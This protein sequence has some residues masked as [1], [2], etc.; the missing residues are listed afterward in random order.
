LVDRGLRADSQRTLF[1]ILTFDERGR[2][3]KSEPLRRALAEPAA[4]R[5]G[6][7]ARGRPA[8][9]G[10]ALRVGE[11]KALRLS[12]SAPLVNDVAERIAE[13]RSFAAAF[14]PVADDLLETFTLWS[15]LTAP[16][17]P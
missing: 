9:L 6:W 10:S 14:Q 8:H 2:A 12:L 1:P 4:R 15:E 17:S 7:M 16:V 11:R 13:G 3:L 5:G